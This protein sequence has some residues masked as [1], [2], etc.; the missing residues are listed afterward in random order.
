MICFRTRRQH[1]SPVDQSVEWYATVGRWVTIALRDVGE[2]WA[3][4]VG[5]D[6]S[7]ATARPITLMV[8]DP[9]LA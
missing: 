3:V 8:H 5:A 1:S 7:V 6:S 2:C 9:G 4:L